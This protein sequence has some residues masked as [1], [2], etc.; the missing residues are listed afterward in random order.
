[1]LPPE[2]TSTTPVALDEFGRNSAAVDDLRRSD[3]TAMGTLRE[4]QTSSASNSIRSQAVVTPRTL[5][6]LSAVISI[7]LYLRMQMGV[8][9]HDSWPAIL[10]AVLVGFRVAR[11]PCAA[12]RISILRHHLV[13]QE[14]I[15][16][17]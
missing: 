17:L 16:K 11:L 15:S 12:R 3:P 4:A 13:E 14:P 6:R 5:D 10:R 8:N 2:A 7:P 1:M 9:E